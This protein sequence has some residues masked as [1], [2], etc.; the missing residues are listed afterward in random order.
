MPS[1]YISTI[2]TV[3]VPLHLSL[4]T[5]SLMWFLGLG[6]VPLSNEGSTLPREPDPGGP[7]H[8]ISSPSGDPWASLRSK[9]RGAVVREVP[10]RTSARW[11]LDS[12]VAKGLDVGG[13][14][15]R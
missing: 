10:E 9:K 11:A 8:G 12:G 15:C 13:Y 7:S 14:V 5:V 1:A 2:R 6:P 4:L 3:F